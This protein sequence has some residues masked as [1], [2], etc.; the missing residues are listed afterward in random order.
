[1]NVLLLAEQNQRVGAII[2]STEYHGHWEWYIHVLQVKNL[3]LESYWRHPLLP[4]VLYLE[5]FDLPV[6]NIKKNKKNAWIQQAYDT[7]VK[8]SLEKD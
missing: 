7:N 1:M 8:S 6:K 4:K 2:Y 3:H 5:N